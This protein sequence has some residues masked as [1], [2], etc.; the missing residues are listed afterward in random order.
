MNQTNFYDRGIPV[1]KQTA[2]DNSQA[3]RDADKA[4]ALAKA[5]AAVEAHSQKDTNGEGPAKPATES[6]VAD[7]NVDAGKKRARE[8]DEGDSEREA[9]KVDTK[10]EVEVTS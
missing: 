2:E 9:K 10:T 4:E 1:V 5:K 8:N 3:K 6:G 7:E